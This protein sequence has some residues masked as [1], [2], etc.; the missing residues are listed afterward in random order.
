MEEVILTEQE[1]EQYERDVTEYQ[2]I[3]KRFT[4]LA[5]RKEDPRMNLRQLSGDFEHVVFEEMLYDLFKRV[6]ALESI[7]K[8]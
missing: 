8:G 6:D 5:K 7:L 2:Q 3:R 1:V 4:Q